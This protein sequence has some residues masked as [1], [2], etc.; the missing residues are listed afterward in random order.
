MTLKEAYSLVAPLYPTGAMDMKT[1]QTANFIID[2]SAA[3]ITNLT[4]RTLNGSGQIIGLFVGQVHISYALTGAQTTILS[5]VYKTISFGDV[6]AIV[7]SFE[8]VRSKAALDIPIG[9]NF[10]EENVIATNLTIDPSTDGTLIYHF[11]GY[12]IPTV[13]YNATDNSVSSID[14]GS[15]ANGSSTTLTF[16]L[17]YRDQDHKGPGWV[18]TLPSRYTAS[19]SSGSGFTST[20][21]VPA[22]NENDLQTIYVKFNPNAVA[23]FNGSMTIV[24]EGFYTKTISLTGSGT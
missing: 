15:R 13:P 23:A 18:L 17:K 22:D 1:I 8:I 24:S 20:L 9:D 5:T 7:P 21:T 6:T 2:G 4:S 11:D 19:L 3:P 10:T 14:F 12:I 16:T